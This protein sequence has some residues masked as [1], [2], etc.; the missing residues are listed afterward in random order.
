M[1]DP[2]VRACAPYSPQ[3]I[4]PPNSTT[5]DFQGFPPHTSSLRLV[6]AASTAEHSVAATSVGAAGALEI[7][8]DEG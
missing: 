5:L 8:V 2:C 1:L 6:A 4:S 7:P 3:R